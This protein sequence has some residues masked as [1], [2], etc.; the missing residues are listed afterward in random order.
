M[1]DPCFRLPFEKHASVAIGVYDLPL[2]RTIILD[3]L[4]DPQIDK[5]VQEPARHFFAY[6]NDC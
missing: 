5:V 1:I 3:L 4:V 2:L 6:L